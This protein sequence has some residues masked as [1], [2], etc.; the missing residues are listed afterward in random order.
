VEII[1]IGFP[2]GSQV[3]TK[4]WKFIMRV[5]LELKVELQVKPVAYADNLAIVVGVVRSGVGRLTCAP[6]N[7]F[8]S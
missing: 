5:A 8:S 6:R 7:I 2:Q 4:L 1:T 3:R